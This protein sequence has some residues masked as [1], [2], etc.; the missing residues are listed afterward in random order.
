[1]FWSCQASEVPGLHFEG[2]RKP[3][4]ARSGGGGGSGF[5]FFLDSGNLSE[6]EPNKS[7]FGGK[8]KHNLAGN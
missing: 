8:Q 1:M 5:R 6:K 2:G 7:V 3:H 4:S